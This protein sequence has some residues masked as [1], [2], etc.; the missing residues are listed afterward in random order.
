MLNLA[1]IIAFLLGLAAVED[2]KQDS[3]IYTDSGSELMCLSARHRLTV[4]THTLD[5]MR[6]VRHD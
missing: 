1:D 6:K 2:T 4:R 5:K 3:D